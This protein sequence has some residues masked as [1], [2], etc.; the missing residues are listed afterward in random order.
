MM[1]S[2]CYLIQS[3]KPYYSHHL[4]FTTENQPL[5][6]SVYL[7]FTFSAIQ[8]FFRSNF[9]LDPV[10]VYYIT[11]LVSVIY[12]ISFLIIL[13]AVHLSSIYSQLVHNFFRTC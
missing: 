10:S 1:I 6:W 2:I 5:Q 12:Y 4:L 11:R 8:T 3:I 13:L 9:F 7:L